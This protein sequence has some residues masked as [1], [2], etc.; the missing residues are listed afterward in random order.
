M[1]LKIGRMFIPLNAISTITP[2]G[3]KWEIQ[4]VN[5]QNPRIVLD[6]DAKGN[7]IGYVLEALWDET[8]AI[9]KKMHIEEM[10]RRKD[11][12]MAKTDAKPN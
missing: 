2:Q 6:V 7:E 9:A 10:A 4:L 12:K 3:N 5:P 8:K 11:E 1:L